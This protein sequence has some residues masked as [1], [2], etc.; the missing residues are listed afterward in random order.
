MRALK[1][2]TRVRVTIE[3]E[4]TVRAQHYDNPES[5]DECVLYLEDMRN[6]LWVRDIDKLTVVKEVDSD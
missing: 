5:P 6:Q 2:N 3:L 1:P 4:L